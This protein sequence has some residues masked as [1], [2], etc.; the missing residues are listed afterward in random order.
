MKEG[1]QNHLL[2]TTTSANRLPECTSQPPHPSA[3][4]LPSELESS[5]RP[6]SRAQS[7]STR[8]ISSV[9]DLSDPSRA[10]NLG[11]KGVVLNGS[12]V[13]GMAMGGGRVWIGL[14]VCCKG[15]TGALLLL[16]SFPLLL[17]CFSPLSFL[18]MREHHSCIVLQLRL[19]HHGWTATKCNHLHS[20]LVYGFDCIRQA[21]SILP[22]RTLPLL[23]LNE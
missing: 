5:L 15:G 7:Q 10:L 6:S 12:W 20:S 3:H 8:R 1:F 23:A 18:Q 17:L 21:M 2:S 13:H 19:L 4:S 16:S 9:V 22:I 11:V 14:C